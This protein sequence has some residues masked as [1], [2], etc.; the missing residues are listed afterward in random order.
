MPGSTAP[1]TTTHGSIEIRARKAAREHGT[2]VTETGL[3]AT[4]ATRKALAGAAR[5]RLGGRKRKRAR[6]SLSVNVSV[7][8]VG[9]GGGYGYGCGGC[10]GGV[11]NGALVLRALRTHSANV[12]SSNAASFRT[13]TRHLRSS[14][15]SLRKATLERNNP[16][17]SL[18]AQL[19]PLPYPTT[20][21]TGKMVIV[22]GANSGLG[23]EAARHFVRPNARKV[24]LGCRD[25]FKGSAAKADI[26]RSEGK[27]VDAGAILEVWHVDMASFA[28]V[29]EFCRRAAELERLDIVVAS[30]GIQTA[31]YGSAE[32]YER[33]ITVNTISTLLLVLRLLR[34]LQRRGAAAGAGTDT[35]S[36]PR[37]TV[38]ASNAHK[39]TSIRPAAGKSI[40]DDMKGAE[41]MLLRYATSKLLVVFAVRE[42]ARRI[43]DWQPRVTLN[44]VDP[45][46]CSS[47]LFRS[48]RFPMTWILAIAL[49]LWG[50]TPEMGSRALG[51]WETHGKYLEDCALGRESAF[52]RSEEGGQVQ[53]KV[54][55]E[56]IAIIENISIGTVREI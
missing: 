49:R 11:S 50:R 9:G 7:G 17:K 4:R 53:A 31:E 25:L 44:M 33:Q 16:L 39:F 1:A 42:L 36:P 30:A 52:V 48:A 28:S 12:R 15:A 2:Q 55:D 22:T 35:P 51:G 29:E 20:D 14:S 5:G 21:C 24:I 3:G 6:G 43:E 34:A 45:G 18:I 13:T 19:R 37:L 26:E 32:G 46:L 8:G 10:G 23:L 27:G 56:L 38:V 54:Y 40:F 41:N 47:Q